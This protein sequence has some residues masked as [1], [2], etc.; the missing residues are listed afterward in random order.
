M[1]QLDE[2][3][4]D[5]DFISTVIHKQIDPYVDL[6]N[7]LLIDQDAVDFGSN[8]DLEINLRNL[9]RDNTQLLINKIWELPISRVEDVIVAKLPKPTTV[10]PREKP[11]PKPKPAT[12]WQKY[13]Q[14]KGIHNK[15]RGRKVWDEQ[16]QSWKPRWGYD[17]AKGSTADWLI[18]VP[19]NTPDPN[20][21]FFEMRQQAKKER[22]AKNELQRLRNVARNSGQN[23]ASSAVLPSSVVPKQQKTAEHYSHELKSAR[24]ATASMGKFT[25]QLP[26]EKPPKNVG[27]KRQVLSNEGDLKAE[28]Q[29]QMEIWDKLN[30]SK[31]ILNVE[32]AIGIVKKQKNSDHSKPA[33]GKKRGKGSKRKQNAR[34]TNKQKFRNRNTKGKH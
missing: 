7:L 16:S 32:K 10:L 25:P 34:A 15:K 2:T 8:L 27:Q 30:K 31:P 19:E 26:K 9:T 4:A 23:S 12:K 24:E 1:Q 28:R 3:V 5:G 29:N 13:A 17:R 18:E 21:D 6:G 11:L 33:G 20:A 14:M 22:V